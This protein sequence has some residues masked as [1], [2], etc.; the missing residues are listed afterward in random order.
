MRSALFPIAATVAVLSYS[1]VNAEETVQLKFGWPDLVKAKVSVET[2]IR[3]TTNDKTHT[4]SDI[5]TFT[6]ESSTTSE[7]HL[8]AEKD[9]ALLEQKYDGTPWDPSRERPIFARELNPSSQPVFRGT[10]LVTK[11]GIFVDVQFC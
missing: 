3:T 1:T 10:Y 6:L 9:H 4:I 5:E 11:D 8:I 2:F 7:G